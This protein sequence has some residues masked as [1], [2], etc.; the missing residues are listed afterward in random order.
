MGLLAH[1]V[2]SVISGLCDQG[3]KGKLVVD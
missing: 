2:G 1:F 3:E